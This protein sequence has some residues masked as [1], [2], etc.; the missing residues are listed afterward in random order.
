VIPIGVNGGHAR[1]FGP[2]TKMTR[3]MQEK[4]LCGRREGCGSHDLGSKQYF[5]MLTDELEILAG[6]TV[7]YDSRLQYRYGFKSKVFEVM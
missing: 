5:I 1:R 6:F 7:S 3:R 4:H 2:K